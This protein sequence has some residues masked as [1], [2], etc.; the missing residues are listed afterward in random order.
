MTNLENRPKDRN[1][2]LDGM[3]VFHSIFEHDI[4]FGSVNTALENAATELSQK[5]GD[6]LVTKGEDRL[7]EIINNGYLI[8]YENRAHNFQELRQYFSNKLP[9]IK[10]LL[11]EHN[12]SDLSD[13]Y[14]LSVYIKIVNCV[15]GVSSYLTGAS[16]EGIDLS[17]SRID[18]IIFDI[19]SSF[20]IILNALED[21]VPADIHPYFFSLFVEKFHSE[22]G[23]LQQ[24]EHTREVANCDIPPAILNS[25]LRCPGAFKATGN[26][27]RDEFTDFVVAMS[28]PGNQP[29]PEDMA[30][31]PAFQ[32]SSKLTVHGEAV[33]T[34]LGTVDFC[35][36]KVS[37]FQMQNRSG[38]DALAIRFHS[39]FDSSLFDDAEISY[40]LQYSVRRTVHE[41]MDLKKR[42]NMERSGNRLIRGGTTLLHCVLMSGWRLAVANV[43]DSMAYMA[44]ELDGV[45]HVEGL[46]TVADLQS[47]MMFQIV[48][49]G[50]GGDL[51]RDAH[52][53]IRYKHLDMNREIGHLEPE[54][55]EPFFASR[56][57]RELA[58][59]G[60]TEVKVVLKSDCAHIFTDKGQI[61]TTASYIGRRIFYASKLCCEGDRS[62]VDDITVMTFELKLGQGDGE[63]GVAATQ[64]SAS[65][66][67]CDG[68]GIGGNNEFSREVAEV[69]VK[70]FQDKMVQMYEQKVASQQLQEK[71]TP[72]SHSS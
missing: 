24:V 72:A 19:D 57:L 22:L 9:I 52:G 50:K 15:I 27:S 44:Y 28:M 34:T 37:H 42:M 18:N 58:Q 7:R 13:H 51:H 8:D 67:I 71:K 66:I 60:V 1:R 26:I 25:I 68:H 38:E 56:D 43:G 23:R 53:G 55:S 6:I 69:Q 49:D 35:G 39:T 16:T 20:N 41:A 59:E 48:T 4:F 47:Y 32:T 61:G 40:A 2:S 45:R 3:D 31:E 11:Q 36:V 14:P 17:F 70:H 5:V 33:E 54:Y 62:G 12:E 64:Q 21:H 65:F 10:D 30:Y 46:T 29:L 63:T